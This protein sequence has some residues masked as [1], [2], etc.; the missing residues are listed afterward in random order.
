[1]KRL[2]FFALLVVGWGAVLCATPVPKLTGRVV[3]AAGVLSSIDLAR[4][5][6][7]L[8]RFEE[9]T[10]GQM[11]VLFE[12]RLPEGETVGSRSLQVAESWKLGRA[13][14]DNGLLLYFAIADRRNRLEVGYGWEGMITDAQAGDIL[15]AMVPFL[16]A[17]KY[18][19]ATYQAIYS[20][21]FRVTGKGI[22][23]PEGV[24]LRAS[25]RAEHSKERAFSR[26]ELLLMALGIGLFLWNARRGGRRGGGGF[27]FFGGPGG[28]ISFGGGGGGFSGGGGSFGGGGASGRW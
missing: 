9:R 26:I 14:E 4:V 13:G 6:E 8:A 3:D 16:K 28:G 27:F 25:R 11:A 21:S 23:L 24:D 1:M 7:M 5:E 12:K 19:E 18:A 17:G 20:A 10:G 22:E 15:R 2:A